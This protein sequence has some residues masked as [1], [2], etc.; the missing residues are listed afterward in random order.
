LAARIA[1]AA[2]GGKVTH[3]RRPRRDLEDATWSAAGPSARDPQA[4]GSLLD[5]VIQE[6]GWSKELGVAS[7][8]GHWADFVG[9]ANA[10]HTTPE[11]FRDGELTVRA[12]STAWATQLRLMA[13]LVVAKLNASLGEETVRFVKILGPK[14]PSWK[15]GKRSVPGRGPRDT[16]G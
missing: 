5:R 13:P 8:M 1:R 7:L 2:R 4:V 6:K 16:Y 3:R 14:T 11:R 10:Q 9:E 15:K 12:E